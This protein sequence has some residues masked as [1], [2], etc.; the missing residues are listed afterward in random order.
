MSFDEGFSSSSFHNDSG[1][2]GSSTVLQPP[3]FALPAALASILV[4]VAIGVFG[5]LQSTANS[6]KTIFGIIGYLLCI[7]IPI[8]LLQLTVSDHSKK[9]REHPEEY[10][11]YGGLELQGKMRKIVLLG[12]IAA[13]IPLFLFTTPIAERFVS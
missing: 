10:N 13:A 8:A 4:G 1:S 11:S 3:K 12:L 6:Q 7:I 2:W 9:L 5:I